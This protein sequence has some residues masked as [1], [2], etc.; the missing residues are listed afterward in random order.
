M[1]TPALKNF[2]KKYPNI[3]VDFL[4]L[5]KISITPIIN[6]GYINDVFYLEK[7]L[8]ENLAL[9]KKIRK[10][11][12]DYIMHSSGTSILKI[13]LVMLLL[14]AKKRIGE[15]EKIMVPWYFKQT[16]RDENTHRVIS[17]KKIFNLIEDIKENDLKPFF[18][19]TKS[20][21]NFVDIFLKRDKFKI[22]IGFHP[23]CNKKFA[24]KRWEFEKYLKT[25]KIL[26]SRYQNA[27]IF[28]FIGP[29]ELDIGKKFDE[30]LSNIVIVKETLSNIAAIIS[31]MDIMITN[32]SGLGHIAGC[33]DVDIL[34]IFSKTTH[35]NP[36][37]IYPYSNKSYIV[38]FKKIETNNE[39]N[40]V[41]S[42]INEILRL[43]KKVKFT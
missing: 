30:Q 1:L 19:L 34:T 25:M 10:T 12:Y 15:F 17:N 36:N 23:G 41:I 7:T 39:I 29:D 28:I 2:Y 9:F 38:D 26:Q 13:S 16:K 32:D 18:Y 31:K 42:R 37:K 24:K 3:Q 27:K 11:K 21:L 43:K 35:A 14:K 8:Y 22:L 4:I 20:N 6:S 33:F 5:Q 40:I